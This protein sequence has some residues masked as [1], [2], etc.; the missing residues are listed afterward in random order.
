MC[1]RQ[2]QASLTYTKRKE[3]HKRETHKRKYI[4]VITS[5][6]YAS[7]VSDCLQSVCDRVQT[8]KLTKT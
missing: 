8:L 4:K 5:E 3:T 2:A 7:M 6:C 1:L